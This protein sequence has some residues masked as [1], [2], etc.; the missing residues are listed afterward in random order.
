MMPILS[1][2]EGVHPAPPVLASTLL[3]LESDHRKA[4]SWAEPFQT[5]V[6]RLDSNLP[7]TLWMGGKV[8][9]IVSDRAE[10]M[11]RI[12]VFKCKRRTGF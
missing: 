6:K 10:S 11:V 3:D 4:T 8:I 7:Q 5:G 1:S 9:G 12:F 2:N